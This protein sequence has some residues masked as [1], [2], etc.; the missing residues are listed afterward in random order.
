MKKIQDSLKLYKNCKNINNKEINRLKIGSNISLWW[1]NDCM[2]RNATIYEETKDK[3][4]F[5]IFFEQ[6]FNCI[7][8]KWIDLRK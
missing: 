1:P 7:C 3:S 6:D 5:Y 2:Y 4:Q 8:G